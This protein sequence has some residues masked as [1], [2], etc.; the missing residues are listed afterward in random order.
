MQ[1]A[2]IN[3]QGEELQRLDVARG[4]DRL[5][6]TAPTVN[7]P[8]KMVVLATFAHGFGQDSVVAP[9]TIRPR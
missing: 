3:D 4:E 8:T 9:V 5:Q 7:A 6:L 1:I 2:L